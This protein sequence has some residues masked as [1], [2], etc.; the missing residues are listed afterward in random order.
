MKSRSWIAQWKETTELVIAR[1][2]GLWEWEITER[3]KSNVQVRDKREIEE[4][5]SGKRNANGLK[6]S[7]KDTKEKYWKEK[8]GNEH[9]TNLREWRIK[10]S[11]TRLKCI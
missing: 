6:D 11:G 7:R 4:E 2:T 5:E 8:Q 3:E 1:T 9:G 10:G